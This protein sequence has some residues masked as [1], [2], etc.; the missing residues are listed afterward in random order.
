[1]GFEEVS[2]HYGAVTEKTAEVAAVGLTGEVVLV[3]RYYFSSA[4]IIVKRKRNK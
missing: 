4:K 2:L 3:K 1:M